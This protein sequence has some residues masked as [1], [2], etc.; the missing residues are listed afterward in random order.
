MKQ[1]SIQDVVAMLLTARRELDVVLTLTAIA[2]VISRA[3]RNELS[4]M[5][6]DLN[7]IIAGL[8]DMP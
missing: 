1:P 2:A 5:R 3:S 6:D 7:R 8:Q 4:V